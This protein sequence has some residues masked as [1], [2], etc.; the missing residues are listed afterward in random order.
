MSE[1]WELLERALP[2]LLLVSEL[3]MAM[4]H[5]EGVLSAEEEAA[6]SWWIASLVR[7]AIG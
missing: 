7:C 2:V 4:P 5:C 1:L 6:V 3:R